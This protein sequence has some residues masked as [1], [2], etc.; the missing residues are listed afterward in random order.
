[1]LTEMYAD[2][3]ELHVNFVKK[4]VSGLRTGFLGLCA[5]MS[6]GREAA[7]P[8]LGRPDS[9]NTTENNG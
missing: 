8:T 3:V 2:V 4:M 9:E 6:T 1:M 7:T 5:G